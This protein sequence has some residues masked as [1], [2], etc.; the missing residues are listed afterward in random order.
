MLITGCSSGIG[1]ATARR[2]A[3][4][5]WDVWATARRPETLDDLRAAGCRTL[6]LDV[7]D[8]A[9]MA[10]AVAAVEVEHGAVAALVNNA[11]YSQSGA[12]E[13]VPMERVRAQ[14]ET[15][16]FGLVELTRL[17]LPG[18]RRRR[19]GRIVNLSSMAAGWCSRAAR[20]TTPQS[21]RS[22]R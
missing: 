8:A 20:S 19:A 11:G 4:S 18:M 22:R 5:G 10:A 15:N 1:E 2:L 17:V 21:M 16:V 14:F 12:F 13:A 9:S 6:A 3:A 7:T